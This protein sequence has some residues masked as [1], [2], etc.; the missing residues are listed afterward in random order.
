[1]LVVVVLLDCAIGIAV[2]VVLTD[3]GVLVVVTG[4]PRVIVVAVVPFVPVALVVV[5][6]LL[7]P[8]ATVV[9]GVAVV[10]VAVPV[11]GVA[12]PVV[13]V[14]AAPALLDV[15]G[16]TLVE[17][18]PPVAPVFPMVTPMDT[19]GAIV[20]VAVTAIPV[21]VGFTLRETPVLLDAEPRERVPV[22]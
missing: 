9:A 15:L 14:T 7:L 16:R 2:P 8:V 18:A 21:V 10:G 3:T 6:V 12:V 19:P 17:L 5:D 22:T 20:A 13:E 1:M 11:V 4:V